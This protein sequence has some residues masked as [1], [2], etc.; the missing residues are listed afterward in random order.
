MK[1]AA[2]SWR[3]GR[4]AVPSAATDSQ[5][6][7]LIGW[8]IPLICVLAIPGAAVRAASAENPRRPNIVLILVD[9]MGFSDLGSY[10]G[11]IKTPNIDR[12]ARDG[13]RFTQFYNT[14]KCGPSRACAMTGLYSQQV[15]M[16]RRGAGDEFLRNSVTV[17]EV[18]QS[19]GYRTLMTGKWH[20]EDNPFNRGFDHYYGLHAGAMNHFNPG[21][22]RPGENAPARKNPRAWIIDDR[23]FGPAEYT[24][25][26]GFYS[27]DAF[28]D[29]AL[30][31]LRDYENEKNPFFLYVAFTAPHFPLHAREE[32]IA[33]YRGGYQEG[34]EVY[35]QRRYEKQQRIGIV[36]DPR[37]MALSPAD[38]AAEDRYFDAEGR[39]DAEGRTRKS[40][41]LTRPWSALNEAER[42]EWD[43]LMATYAAMVDRVDQ[44]VGRL[45]QFL[46]DRG[47]FENTLILFCSDNG[48]CSE[49]MDLSNP[50]ARI[51]TMESYRTAD[52]PW[53]N[54]SNTPLRRF[55]HWSHEGGITTPL[56]A[57][58]PAAIRSD[59]EA[60]EGHGR[61]TEN[62]GHFID[63]M[64]TFIEISGG[65]YPSTH[66]GEPV[67]PVEGQSL[68]PLF[69]FGTR[70]GHEALFWEY[71]GGAA[72]RAGDWKLTREPGGDWELYDL[73]VD[74]SEMND[75]AKP[76]PE[77]RDQLIRL[78]NRWAERPEID[79]PRDDS[80]QPDHS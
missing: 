63:F 19:A 70:P 12:L 9:D 11:E 18:L 29:Q 39:I 31:Y 61:V 22:Q 45:V 20:G 48:A 49:Y 67:F 47:Q 56:I 73:S 1:H 59:P 65:S 35:R 30:Q 69:A 62:I 24:P 27:T 2:P 60:F 46:Q 77:K 64:P 80:L 5:G 23:V 34:W 72:V 13:L 58:W 76:F 8:V 43:H 25:E 52:R 14:A 21:Q 55:K 36:R 53:A 71:E 16:G 42:D 6:N 75:L 68:Y 51:G 37:R 79:L 54:V 74:R 41:P 33:K 28:M 4:P 7:S 38:I 40:N 66:R 3:S 78:F 44:Q 17:T 32:D 26:P 15:G 50:G 10:G 57:H